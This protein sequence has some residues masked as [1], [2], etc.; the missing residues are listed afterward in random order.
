[1]SATKATIGYLGTFNLGS[2]LAPVLEIKHIAINGLTIPAIDATHLLS[3]NATKEKLPGIIDPKD[4]EITGNFVG[5]A[6]QL[7]FLTNAQARTV[8]AW[9][10]TAKVNSNTQTYTLSGTGFVADYGHG[11]IEVDKVH[12]FTAKIEI[13]GTLT[14]AV[15]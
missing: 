12:E 9:S 7:A 5:D 6:T 3:P 8:F 1:M 4:I 14:E 2:P 10:V 15:A 11:A 13:T